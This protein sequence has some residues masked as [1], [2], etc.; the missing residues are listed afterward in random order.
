[1]YSRSQELNGRPKAQWSQGTCTAVHENNWK[2]GDLEQLEV[3]VLV[4]TRAG[5]L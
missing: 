1:M 2:E 3:S 4:D 5:N